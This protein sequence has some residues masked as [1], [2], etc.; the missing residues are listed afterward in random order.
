VADS[1]WSKLKNAAL[2]GP[3]PAHI[4]TYDAPE[5]WHRRLW[6]TV[7]LPARVTVR[8]AFTRAQKGLLAGVAAAVLVS[9]GA[10]Y[11]YA[12]VTS[13]PDRSARAISE[14]MKLLGPGEFG[15][16]AGRFSEALE[17]WPSN[18]RAFLER[19]NAYKAMGNTEEAMADWA[20]AIEADPS[21]AAAYT[22]R[23]T[24]YRQRGDYSWALAD[25]DRSIQL[26]PSVDAY[27]QRGQ[28]YQALG[29]PERAVADF[30]RGIA[31]R[32]EAPF[33][34]RARGT[35]RRA[36]GD[37]DGAAADRDTADR[38]EALH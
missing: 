27:Y 13:A 9:G 10:W 4:P 6:Q 24:E 8:R 5:P 34:Y 29:Q 19:G 17:I 1:I 36:L 25:L 11:A 28:V 2:G 35:A 7:R 30:D 12:Y 15:A 38:L 32:R 22:A 37:L 23:G 33:L 18:A 31:E 3:V 21:L 14:G 20:R 16:A 26:A